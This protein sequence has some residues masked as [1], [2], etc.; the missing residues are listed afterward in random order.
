VDIAFDR[1]I[2]RL[3]AE[4]RVPDEDYSLA[5]V[6]ELLSAGPLHYPAG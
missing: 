4:L 6:G 3:Y 5:R 1:L 2:N